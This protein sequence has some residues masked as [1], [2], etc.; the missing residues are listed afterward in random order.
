MAR[1]RD[2]SSLFLHQIYENHCSE[3]TTNKKFRNDVE[4]SKNSVMIY[5]DR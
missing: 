5:I 2:Y 4:N 1:K 3:V